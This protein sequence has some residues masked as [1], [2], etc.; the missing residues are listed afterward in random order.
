MTE[1]LSPDLLRRMD[2][3]WRAANYLAVGQIYLRDAARQRG[4]AASSGPRSITRT[5]RRTR[6]A[7][8]RTRTRA[9]NRSGPGRAGRLAGAGTT[10]AESRR[11]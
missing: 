1:P 2:A 7:R 8:T 3:Y 10:H 4:R 9:H 6:R 11:P 5:G